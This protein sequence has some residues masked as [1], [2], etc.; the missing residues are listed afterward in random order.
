M[1]AL[2]EELIR[3]HVENNGIVLGKNL[4]EKAEGWIPLYS[5]RLLTQLGCHHDPF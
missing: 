1:I 4:V 2:V 3:L 5:L